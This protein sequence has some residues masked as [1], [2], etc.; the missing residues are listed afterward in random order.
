LLTQLCSVAFGNL[1]PW[2]DDSI[3]RAQRHVA[4]AWLDLHLVSCR[5]VQAAHA[6]IAAH[7]G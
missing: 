7:R 6:E 5:A 2:T 3:T 4:R 1:D